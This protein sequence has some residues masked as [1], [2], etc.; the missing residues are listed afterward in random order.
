MEQNS[1]G[2]QLPRGKHCYH[3]LVYHSRD[4]RY[5]THRQVLTYAQMVNYTHCY[6]LALLFLVYFGV[7]SIIST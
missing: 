7:H 2:P 5:S 1:K 6:D 3:Y 4:I